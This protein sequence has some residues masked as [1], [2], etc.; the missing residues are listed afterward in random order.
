[1]DQ[2]ILKGDIEITDNIDFVREIMYS[3]IPNTKIISLD[4]NGTLP[5]DHPNVLGGVCLLP[6]MDA[7]I[8]EADGDEQSF[9]IIYFN[10]FSEPFV[11]QFVVAL[12]T[13]LFKGGHLILYYPEL[14]SVIG[15]KLL[16]MFWN[17]YGINI[18]RVG[19]SNCS[20]DKSCTPI[21]LGYMYSID[22]L[23]SYELLYLYP[24]DALIPQQIMDKLLL[25]ISPYRKDFQDKVDYILALR[26]KLKEQP[27]LKIP[28]H[29]IME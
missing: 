5:L 12:I 2:C 18:G 20:Y 28:I 15:T 9:D 24:N 16:Q 11:E 17:K 22:I 19:F 1:M 13:F 3:N 4:E 23:S 29:F 7:L 14:N 25:D 10:H 6:P 21:W 26:S 27:Y 8:A